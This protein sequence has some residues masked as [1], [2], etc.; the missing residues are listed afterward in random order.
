[1]KVAKE[2]DAEKLSTASRR[3]LNT[4]WL[5]AGGKSS[6]RRFS[7]QQRGKSLVHNMQA[8][9]EGGSHR[10]RRADVSAQRCVA[11]LIS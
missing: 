8:K 4:R 5:S 10:A 11:G 2:V 1:M 3:L 6:L 9:S 7:R